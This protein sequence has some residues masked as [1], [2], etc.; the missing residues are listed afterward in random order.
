LFL[1]TLGLGLE[2]LDL[3]GSG[4]GFDGLGVGLA[5]L[6]L[7]TSLLMHGSNVTDI[8]CRFNKKN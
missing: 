1:V 3:E 2:G 4:L 5:I 7:T 8:L 6:S